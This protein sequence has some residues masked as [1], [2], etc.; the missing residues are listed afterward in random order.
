M[1]AVE[2]GAHHARIALLRRD[3]H[4]ATT[5]RLR[6]QHRLPLVRRRCSSACRSR[7]SAIPIC[8]RDG[9]DTCV[10]DLR[11]ESGASR[12]RTRSCRL[13]SAAAG[14]V[15]AALAIDPALLPEAGAVAAAPRRD[16][17]SPRA[18]RFRHRRYAAARAARR[19]AGR[20]RRSAS[21]PRCRTS[22]PTCASTRCSRRSRATRRPPSA[23]RS[24]RCSWTTARAMRCRSS[25]IAAGDVA[26]RAREWADA[27]A[28]DVRDAATLID[29]LTRRAR[30]RRARRSTARSPLRSLCAAP[31]VYRGQPLGVLV[32]LANGERGF[33]PHDVELLQS[34]AVAGRD[35]AHATRGCTRRSRRSPAATRSPGCSTTA[36]STSRSRAS[37]SAAAATAAR[38]PSCCST[39]TASSRSTT[40]AA[41]PRATACSRRRRRARAALPRASDLAFRIG[42]DEFALLLPDTDGARGDQRPPSAR[43]RR[44]ARSTSASASRTASPN[45]PHDGP[46]EGH[47]CSRAPTEPLRDEALERPRPAGREARRGPTTESRA[48]ASASPR[49]SRLSAAARAAARPRRRSPRAT[50]DELHR[51]FGYHLVVVHRLDDDGMLRPA[52]GARAAARRDGRLDDWEQPDDCGVNGRAVRTGEP[53]ARAR[54]R[55][56]TPTSSASTRRQDGRLRARRAD[57]RGRRDLGRA[58]PRGARAGRVRRRRPACSPT[59]WPRTWAPRSTAAACSASSRARS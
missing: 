2:I 33:L 43:P 35:R 47:R 18:A 29:D 15:G 53:V 56:A 9:G 27:A 38:W 26:R 1:E 19:A 14:V 6:A 22:S 59:C 55:A 32:A 16:G 52:A 48:S 13:R 7:A 54:H 58:Q 17:G 36:S 23:A 50:V 51:A 30:A 3:R 10:Y 25:S 57:P 21:R 28:R 24:S 5:R 37:S 39:S 40:R 11:W 8:A 31:L 41:M 34:Y 20:R 46:D 44:C 4:A 49:A 12:M 45:G 42:G